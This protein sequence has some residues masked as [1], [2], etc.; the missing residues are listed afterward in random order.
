MR[1]RVLVALD[2]R[3]L[4]METYYRA[5]C[6][7]SLMCVDM[8]GSPACRR[9]TF[10]CTPWATSHNRAVIRCRH[11]LFCDDVGS[12]SGRAAT[13]WGITSLSVK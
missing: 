3:W 2:A 10:S 11:R 8:S 7:P 9:L 5:E 1:A 6:P 4:W 12:V 13:E